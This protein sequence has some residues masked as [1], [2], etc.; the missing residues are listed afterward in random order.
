MKIETLAYFMRLESYLED[1]E[2]PSQTKQ[3]TNTISIDPK[4]TLLTMLIPELFR[5][6]LTKSNNKNRRVLISELSQQ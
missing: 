6:A 1:S 3:R 5:Y 4:S 2:K